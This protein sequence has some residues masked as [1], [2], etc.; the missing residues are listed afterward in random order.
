MDGEYALAE[1]FNGGEDV[2]GEFSLAEGLG[3]A[4]PF[5]TA[6]RLDQAGPFARC[7]VD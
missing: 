3:V 2:V 1:A 4:S 7:T 5:R 6:W